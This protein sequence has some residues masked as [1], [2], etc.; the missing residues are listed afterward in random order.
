[1]ETAVSGAKLWG[2]G[3]ERARSDGD[4]SKQCEA[5]KYRRRE[6]EV[7]IVRRKLLDGVDVD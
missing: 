6:T 4:S 2:I 1:M 7:K 3:E 5:I